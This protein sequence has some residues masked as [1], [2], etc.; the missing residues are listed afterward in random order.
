MARSGRSKPGGG[1]RACREPVSQQEPQK[2]TGQKRPAGSGF[3]DLGFL[4]VGGFSLPAF[5]NLDAVLLLLY[6]PL[7]LP[8]ASMTRILSE[9]PKQSWSSGFWDFW[10]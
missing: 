6:A 5:E 10:A 4:G 1:Q 7:R 3:R 9:P 8:E 2:A